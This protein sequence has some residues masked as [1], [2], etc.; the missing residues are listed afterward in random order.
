[1][2]KNAEEYLKKSIDMLEQQRKKGWTFR[3]VD[4]DAGFNTRTPEIF[5]TLER[6]MYHFW[7][8]RRVPLLKCCWRLILA[9]FCFQGLFR[10]QIRLKIVYF[11][12]KYKIKSRQIM[13]NLIRHTEVYEEIPQVEENRD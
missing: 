5:I 8:K 7:Y 13:K 6:P 12:R 3:S 4:N 10:P 1:M 9:Y 2:M 11:S